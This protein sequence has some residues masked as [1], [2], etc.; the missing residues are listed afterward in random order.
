MPA[1]KD[2]IIS[3]FPN[4]SNTRWVSGPVAIFTLVV[5]A[6]AANYAVGNHDETNR[7][8]FSFHVPCEILIAGV[9]P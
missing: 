1:G 8:P 4:G 5:V 7:N 6:A 2:M 9:V 3:P